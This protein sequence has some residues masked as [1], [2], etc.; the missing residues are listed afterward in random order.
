MNNFDRV[1]GILQEMSPKNIESLDADHFRKESQSYYDNNKSKF[2][3]TNT[4]YLLKSGDDHNGY[5][6]LV[7]DGVVEYFANYKSKSYQSLLKGRMIRQVLVQ[8]N[9][10]SIDSANIPKKVFFDYLLPTFGTI[11]TDEEQTADGKKFW[12]HATSE[13]LDN[14]DKY[15]VYVLNKTKGQTIEIVDHEHFKSLTDSIWGDT[16]NFKNIWV[17]ISLT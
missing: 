2:K 5:Y 15:T 7:V 1:L 16:E 12:L 14:P 3:P 11:V 10:F 4:K 13:A 17:A 8:R 6:M 9:H